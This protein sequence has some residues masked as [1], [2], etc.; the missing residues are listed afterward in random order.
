MAVS[1]HI[2]LHA[3]LALKSASMPHVPAHRR[4]PITELSPTTSLARHVPPAARKVS[5][6]Q[7]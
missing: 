1:M 2:T 6:E 7:P 4:S 3:V 5:G